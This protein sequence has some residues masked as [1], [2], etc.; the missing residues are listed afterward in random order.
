MPSLLLPRSRPEDQG[1]PSA[2]VAR[3]VAA[4]DQIA[5]VHT[6]T[7][8][9]HGHVVAEFAR[10]PYERD[11]PH[12]LYSVSKSFTSIAIGIA[13]DE[14]RFGLDDRV[15][16]LLA[17]QAPRHPAAHLEALTVRQV[18]TMTTGHDPEPEDWDGDGDWARTILSSGAAPHARDPL[19]VQHRRYPP[20]LAD[21][22]YA[23]GRATARLPDAA[24][25]PASRVRRP[26][27]A[28]TRRGW[29]PE[30]SASRS[31]RRSSPPSGS[32]SCS[33]GG[34]KVG[35][36]SCPRSGSIWRRA[37]RSPTARRR[38]RR[39][40]GRA[41]ASSLDVPARRLPGRRRV[42]PVC[43]RPGRPRRGGHDDRGAARHA[44]A[45]RRAVGDASAFDT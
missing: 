21:H 30:D 32:C 41:T 43:R 16:D 28:P 12:A 10:P 5:H 7:V 8:T 4:L 45:A 17:D 27:M 9:R 24:P 33:A 34:G 19:A 2:A 3:L 22:P 25:L 36:A 13:I 39:T 20:A 15:I 38:S 6:L 18:L 42:R 29:M 26:D 11:A 37:G 40:G 14:G 1:L 35:A 23:H 44:A 31:A